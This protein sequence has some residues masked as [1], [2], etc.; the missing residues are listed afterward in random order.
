MLDDTHTYTLVFTGVVVA[1]VAFAVW[2]IFR[3]RAS[4]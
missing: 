1:A 3:R 4:A 2:R